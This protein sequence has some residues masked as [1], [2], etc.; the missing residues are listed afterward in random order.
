MK[1]I[2]VILATALALVSL[3]AACSSSKPTPAAQPSNTYKPPV[4]VF[5]ATVDGTTV[6]A[7]PTKIISLSS[8]ATDMLFSIGAGAQVIEVDKYSDYFGAQPPATTPPADIDATA[9]SAEAIAAKSPDLVVIGFDANKIKENLTALKIPVYE[10]DAAQ[11][12]DDTYHQITALGVLTG[13]V[14]TAANVVAAE[15]AQ[16]TAEIAQL[17]KPAGQLSYYYELDPTAFYSATS[18]TFIGSLFT[19][20]NMTNIADPADANGSAGG[21]PQLTAESIIKANPNLIFLADTS[22][23]ATPETVAA[24]PGWS[25]MDAVKKKQI[26]N[27]PDDIASQWGTRVPQLLTDIV[28]AVKAYP[29]A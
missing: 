18:K 11:T 16:I 20:A 24:R 7:R 14:E 10:A 23:K 12:L 26:I 6:A 3:T 17:P 9:P 2:P 29:A 25:T 5:P 19:M 15:K 1:R 13:N 4:A 8:T 27:I 21:Y 22:E 28:N